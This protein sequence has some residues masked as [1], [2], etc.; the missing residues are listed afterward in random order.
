MIPKDKFDALFSGA[1]L[2][3]DYEKFSVYC[4]LLLDWNRRMNLTAITDDEGIAVKHF[5]D[6]VLPL[7]LWELPRGARLI[8]VGTGAGFPALPMK[9]V[10][11][12]LDVTLLDSQQKRLDF[13]AAV[14]ARLEIPAGWVHLRAEDAGRSG[15]HRGKYDV[16]VS[17]AVASMSLLVEYCLPLL[18]VGG[19]LLAMKG[20]GGKAETEEGRPAIRALGGA[21]REVME[22][23]LPGGDRRTL[24]VVEKVEET[25]ARYPRTAAQLAKERRA[26]HT[27]SRD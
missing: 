16:A 15:E 12:D 1:G 7:T 6:S 26:K 27:G 11:E 4:G 19:V 8:D 18:R 23:A 17:R 22:Y 10:R 21:V 9:L 5:L 3:G 24:V 20:S 2:T 13:L 25:P 14:C